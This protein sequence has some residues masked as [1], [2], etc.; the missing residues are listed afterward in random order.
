M[1]KER[2][3][4][5]SRAFRNPRRIQYSHK[6]IQRNTYPN[7]QTKERKEFKDMNV[8][9]EHLEIPEESSIPQMHT[10]EYWSK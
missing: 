2:Y 3:E 4:C 8:N 10:K 1:S 7:E 5:Q 6:C 9:L